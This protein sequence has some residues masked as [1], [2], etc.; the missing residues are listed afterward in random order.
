MKKHR[1]LESGQAIILIVFSM[2]GLIGLTALTVDGGI[3][4]LD[5]RQAQS[6]SDTAAFAAARAKIRGEDWKAAALAMAALNGYADTNAGTGSSSTLINVEVYECTEAHTPD[7]GE[8]MDEAF[9]N[10]DEYIHV[11]ITSRVD[12]FFGPIVGITQVTNRV[13]TI[14]HAQPSIPDPTSFGNAV[15]SL[16]PGC[17][18]SSWN[19]DPY[20]ISGNGVTTITGSGVKINSSCANYA[21]TQNGGG[22]LNS[23]GGTC[24]VGGIDPSSVGFVSPAPT[25]D[26]E[27][28]PERQWPNPSCDLDG[29]GDIDTSERGTITEV[30]GLVWRAT[31]GYYDDGDFPSDA[32]GQLFLEKGIYCIVDGYDFSVSSTLSIST[33]VNENGSHDYAS[34]GVLIVVESGGITLNGSSEFDLHA[35]SDPTADIEI[36]NLLFYLPPGNDSTVRITGNTNST[37]TGSIWAPSALITLEGN[38]GTTVNSQVVGYSVEVSGGTGLAINYDENQNAVT[39]A[40][41][42]IELNK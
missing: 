10:P 1:K 36:Q 26:C 31:P 7:C 17:S 5:R 28:S 22:T 24:V 3:A 25:Q 18:D 20:K 29:Q 12:T 16:M 34:E 4:Y 19:K 13:N 27:V 30:V 6:A 40:P 9:E 33:D 35:I 38:G 11:L 42:Q 23:S 8:Y 32:V 39:M 14:T 2:V 15:E 37:F 21:L 41:A